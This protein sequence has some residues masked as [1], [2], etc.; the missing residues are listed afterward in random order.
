MAI[1]G[2]LLRPLARFFVGA[3]GIVLPDAAL[4][5]MF[6]VTWVAPSAL[7][8][9][10]IGYLIVTLVL[11]FVVIHSSAFMGWVA[12]AK[13]PRVKRGVAMLA[14]GGLYTA[15]VWP[16]G[17]LSGETWIIWAFWA[18]V[19]NRTWAAVGPA[20]VEGAEAHNKESWALSVI[21][22]LAAV[23]ITT[24]I[25]MPALGITDAAWTPPANS[26]GLWNQKPQQ[27]LAAGL[28]YFGGGAAI[29]QKW[30]R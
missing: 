22:Y 9:A 21:V 15:F 8:E 5:L 29:R 2:R 30:F 25:P 24:F 10:M 6:L 1:A 19:L 7:G 14:L 27:A 17:T 28:L 18:L 13:M 11:E 12:L 3:V 4:A 16:I 23:F 26:G 20:A